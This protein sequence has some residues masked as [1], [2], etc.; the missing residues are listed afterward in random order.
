VAIINRLV[1]AVRIRL[2]R[3]KGEAFGRKLAK[4]TEEDWARMKEQAHAY[5]DDPSA[6]KT[7]FLGWMQGLYAEAT[8]IHAAVE[9]SDAEFQE[10][11]YAAAIR[12]SGRFRSEV[13]SPRYSDE[14]DEILS[15][16]DI[17]RITAD[18]DAV[19]DQFFGK[20]DAEL[21]VALDRAVKGVRAAE[22]AGTLAPD[23]RLRH[24]APSPRQSRSPTRARLYAPLKSREE[25][26]QMFEVEIG[27]SC[28]DATYQRSPSPGPVLLRR[29][30]RT[31]R[32]WLR[33]P[34]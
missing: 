3:R 27:V 26:R 25:L 11:W 15:D 30:D 31:R 32:A 4:Q 5:Y 8:A 33:P 19:V 28:S 18:L 24:L 14:A 10:Y 1:R 23:P 7:M 17:V 22:A 16:E 21:D 12:F 6:L 34:R 9:A 2:A 20:R 13:L 29:L